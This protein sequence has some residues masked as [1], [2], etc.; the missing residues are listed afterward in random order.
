MLRWQPAQTS[1]DSPEKQELGRRECP[2]LPS[3]VFSSKFVQSHMSCLGCLLM[4]IAVLLWQ[5]ALL[6]CWIAFA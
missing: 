6:L 4:P 2:Y 5:T 3:S 1:V